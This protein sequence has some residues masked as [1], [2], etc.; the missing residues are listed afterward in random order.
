MPI[1]GGRNM[2]WC[3]H[4]GRICNTSH[5]YPTNNTSCLDCGKILFEG[6]LTTNESIYNNRISHATRHYKGR[7]TIWCP[8]CIRKNH[9]AHDHISGIIHCVDCGKVLLEDKNVK[10]ATL[11]K[12]KRPKLKKKRSSSKMNY[13]VINTLVGEKPI[14]VKEEDE[15]SKSDGNEWKS[16][17]NEQE[18]CS[19]DYDYSYNYD[20]DG[21]DENNDY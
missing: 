21:G 15:C 7:E 9:I 3:S 19:Y 6:N 5:D 11:G 17:D 2:E 4:C 10:N 20:Y 1:K 16:Y 18:S 14:P 8:H 12:D 13:D